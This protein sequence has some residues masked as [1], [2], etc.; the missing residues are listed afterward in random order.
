MAQDVYFTSNP[1]EFTEVEGL[2]VVEKDPPGF[3]QGRNLG[4]TGIAGVCVRGPS[5]V[6]MITSTSRFLEVYGGRD[7]GSGGPLVGQVWRALLNKPFG[8]LYVRRVVAS[9]AD[10][11]FFTAEEGVDGAGTE[12]LK[13]AAS[14]AG[15][16]GGD[17]YW[18]IVDASDG[19]AD[20]FNLEVKYLGEIVTFENLN[21][22]TAADDNLAEVVGDDVAR[23]IDLTKVA[24]GRPANS[25]TITETDFVAARDTDNWVA[26]GAVGAAWTD[27]DGADGTIASAQEIAALDDLAYTP[28]PYGILF[29]GAAVDQNALNGEMVTLAP[30]L[31]DKVFLTWAGTHAQAVATEI[32][33]AGTDITTRSDRIVWCFNSA[34]TL[35]PDTGLEIQVPP[36][37]FMASIWSQTDVDVHPGARPNSDYLSGIR[38]LANETMTRGDLVA[39]RAAGISTLEKLPDGAFSFRSAVVTLLTSGKTEIARRR[40][41]DYLQLSAADRLRFY[42]KAKNTLENRA[43]MAGELV[44]FSNALKDAGRIVADFAIDQ[45]MN[46]EQSRGQGIEKIRWDVRLIG[47]MLHLI[48]ETVIGTT[49]TIEE[50]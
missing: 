4:A 21:I 48:L 32:T 5:T 27:Q 46:T 18:R 14:S 38:R 43:Q 42:V 49:V 7:R 24:S 13:I 2:Y 1:A 35:D 31:A 16:W 30:L 12:V 11:A 15:A 41:A 25:S 20:H 34:W 33:N 37:E 29:A 47:H 23:W 22:K 28:G 45:S 8:T 39:L 6:Q 9:D 19:N 10:E 26:L 17:L 50:Q 40:C 36:H 3:I 44:A